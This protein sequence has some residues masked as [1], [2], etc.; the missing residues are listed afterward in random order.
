MTVLYADEDTG[1]AIVTHSM[2]KQFRR[3][4]KATQYKYAERLRPKMEGQAL[5]RGKWVHACLEVHYKG[6]DWREE[7]ARWVNQFGR[8]FDEE[9]ARLGNLPWEI[10]R[11]MKGYFWHY[12][13]D[14]DWKVLETEFTMEAELPDGTLYRCRADNLVETPYGVFL[15]DH[16]SHKTLPGHEFRLRDTQSPLYIWCARKNGIPVQ[17]F[18]WNYLRTSVQSK[19][20]FKKNGDLYARIGDTDYPSAFTDL[21]AADKN[22]KDEMWADRLKVLRNMRYEFGRE[23]LSPFFRRVVMEKDD[24]MIKQCLREAIHTVKRMHKYPFNKVDWVERVPDRSC[25][26]CSF[27][28]V[29]TTEL[30]GGN[31]DF[32]RRK[33]FKVGDPMDYYQEQKEYVS[34]E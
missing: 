12:K 5:H 20:R 13:F 30:I 33:G 11:L 29:C 28:E 32:I 2:I 3:C 7:H 22:P 9:K 24:A 6:G 27:R 25:D 15:V 18:I 10:E 23:Q 19:W 17:G 26:W 21:K 31:V 4:P 16:K 14:Q 34:N 8:L 1:Q